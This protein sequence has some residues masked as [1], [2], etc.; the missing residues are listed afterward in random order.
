MAA[1]PSIKRI[2]VPLEARQQSIEYDP[3]SVGRDVKAA[4]RGRRIELGQPA[5]LHRVEIE[6]K[7]ADAD[8]VRREFLGSTMIKL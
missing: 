2:N 8:A 3:G 5:A 1:P 7:I 4:H 6:P